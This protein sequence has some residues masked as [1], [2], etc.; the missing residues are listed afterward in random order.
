[1]NFDIKVEIFFGGVQ[2][3]VVYTE[4]GESNAGSIVAAGNRL[5]RTL[6]ENQTLL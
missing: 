4:K 5:R 3:M 2:E 1:M 6:V